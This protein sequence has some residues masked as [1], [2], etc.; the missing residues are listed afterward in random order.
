MPYLSSSDD[1]EKS[2]PVRTGRV[3]PPPQVARSDLHSSSSKLVH[4]ALVLAAVT[5]WRVSNI[6]GLLSNPV[7]T[8]G[9][10]Q[11]DPTSLAR[12]NQL[13][14]RCQD[15]HLT[16]GVPD[17]FYKRQTSDRFVPGARPILI[18]NASVWTGQ[19]DGNE[20]LYNHDVL[21]DQGLI[22]EINETIH[23]RLK[24]LDVID[25][26][27]AWLTPG[28]VD[29][30]SHIGV[31]S[32]PS[33]S[34]SDDTNSVAAPTLP[35]LRSLDGINTH[36]LAFKRT[37]SGGVTTSLVLP[38]SANS[39]GGQAFVIKLR[40]TEANT[41]DSLVVEMPWDVRLPS[42]EQKPKGERPRWRRMKMA[43]GENIKRVHNQVR[44]DNSWNFRSAFD[45][46]RTLKLKQDAF[47][48]NTLELHA[49]GHAL[50][51]DDEKSEFPDDLKLEA[52][53]DV[54][55]GK[56]LVN[57]HCYETTDLDQF[58][59][60]THEFE[61][62]IAAFHHAHE[63]YLVPDL[64]KS[65]WPGNGSST[66][67]VA[68]F[69]TNARYKREAWRGSEYAPRILAENNI[70]VIMKSDHPVLDSRYLLFE[71]QQAHHFGLPANLALAA[72]TTSP[73]QVAGLSHRV[74]SISI[75]KDADV[76]LWSSHPLSL[77][78]T[79]SQVIID[80]IPQLEHPERGAIDLPKQDELTRRNGPRSAT[81]PRSKQFPLEEQDDGFDFE[82]RAKRGK[83]WV[84]TVK[85][86]RVKEVLVKRGSI[87]EGRNVVD[88]VDGIDSLVQVVVKNGKIEC[89]AIDCPDVA[90]STSTKIVDLDG[91]SLLPSF[92]AYGPALGLSDITSEK[93]TLDA[94]VFDPLTHG[95]LSRSQQDWSR[96]LSVRAID[97][98]SFGGKHLVV[99][100]ESGV[101][102]AITAPNGNGFYRGISVAFRTRAKNILDHE[103]IVEA[104]AALHVALGHY[105]GAQ[106]PSVST[107][108]AQLRSLLLTGLDPHFGK[109]SSTGSPNRFAM[110]A[111]G[112]IP[113]V[114]EV[115]KA[116]TI[117]SLIL[118]KREIETRAH[119]R[120]SLKWIIAGGQE[121]H[122]VADELAQASIGVILSPPRSFPESWDARRALPG[123]PLT[124]DTHTTVLHRAGV[125]VALGLPEEWQTRTLLF[126][127]AWAQR[128]SRDEISRKE[129]IEFI[130]SNF[131]D[132]FGINHDEH[133]FVAFERDPFE[134]GSRMV[135]Q[136]QKGGVELRL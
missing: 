19:Y 123:P 80:G 35:H 109:I 27:G 40:P 9:I 25:A 101:G 53:V 99:A 24:D 69:A 84:E 65:A 120:Y 56:V 79:P 136:S 128:L 46:A 110:A 15:L 118:L 73:A 4:L 45:Q 13:V 96:R 94:K 74:G 57:T 21:L 93:S 125:K 91:G 107:Q 8:T 31:D 122:L 97:G 26:K 135:A 116:D 32:M 89:V 49:R 111:M 131:E 67:A 61:F 83:Q 29:M 98:L 130:S 68:L 87:E 10:G 71:A 55:R 51:E 39:I 114:V 34:G 63:A 1:E 18:R 133:D 112:E 59:R 58:V 5:A 38:G 77:G 62:P 7:E 12:W 44:M 33:L 54:L 78:A 119:G 117:A 86:V 129:A 17:D 16:P 95:E 66:P 41:P 82:D 104:E 60:H 90:S 52:L 28:I 36:D 30:H 126:E 11:L 50:K 92:Y 42:R 2:K 85:F 115:D 47:C 105:K 132:M 72:V 23:P 103:A 48:R 134:F 81:V 20:I 43:C 124:R 88:L 37:V 108:I 64:L 100:D 6:Y 70:T 106:E 102:K 3:R 75:N 127:A 76:V 121:A 22:V 113:L 14:D